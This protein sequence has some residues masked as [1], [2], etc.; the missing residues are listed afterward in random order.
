MP[1]RLTAADKI[2]AAI[3]MLELN[4]EF[5]PKSADIDLLI[6]D[7]YR[8]KGEREKA[9]DELMEIVRSYLR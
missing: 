8:T 7:L 9:T 5:N 4:G 6:G 3:A 1:R 2:D